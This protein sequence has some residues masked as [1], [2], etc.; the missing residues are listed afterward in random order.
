MDNYFQVLKLDVDT[1]I[2]CSTDAELKTLKNQSEAEFNAFTKV[3]EQQFNDAYKRILHILNNPKIAD[4]KDLLN[5]AK[6]TL[7]DRNTRDQHITDL[8]T[9]QPDPPESQ[10]QKPQNT[11]SLIRFSNGDEATSIPHLATLMEKNAKEA[12]DMLYQGDVLEK[13]LQGAG[14]T[15]AARVANAVVRQ[16]PSEQNIGLM[17]I[18][19]VFRGKILMQKGT[20]AN[21]PQQLARLI[22]QNWEQAKTLLYNGFIEFWLEHT[23]QSQL[24]DTANK[25][26]N[27]SDPQDTGL[28]MLVQALDPKI[29]TPK[30]EINQSEIDFGNMKRGSQKTI[31]LEIKNA[32]RGFLYGDV[33]LTNS[34]PGL[35]VSDMDIQGD[36]VITLQLDAKALTSKRVSYQESLVINTSGGNLKVPLYINYNYKT[37][38]L[39]HRV[40]ISGISL[41][42]ILLATRL[43]IHLFGSSDW[44]ATHLTGKGFEGWA[45]HLKWSV[46]TEFPMFDWRVYSMRVSGKGMRF[47]I[48]LTAL[49]IGMFVY[50]LLVFSQKPS[51]TLKNF[52]QSKIFLKKKSARP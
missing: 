10:P 17:A 27:R 40:A 52:I 51:E 34:I 5:L 32:G 7:S 42:G 50:W 44:L 31:D 9:P 23:K 11:P 13:G 15:Q 41:A 12:T 47:I 16:F 20:G 30:L 24:A 25:I 2:K 37:R 48:A 3:V 28:E 26:T 43:I 8:L 45:Q 33:Q 21:T 35:K 1:N 29:G 18:V 49:G 6:K 39:A 46:W 19:A 38:Q 4:Q 36:H 22:D 14:E